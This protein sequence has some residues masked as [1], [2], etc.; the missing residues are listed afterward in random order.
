MR[1]AFAFIRAAWLTETSYRLNM[2]FS[3]ASLAFVVVPL[4]FVASA[5]EHTMASSIASQSRQYFSFV[6][7][8]AVVFN[9]ATASASALPNAV[10]NAIGRG[11]LESYLST[12]AS[13]GAVFAGLSGYGVVWAT[14]RSAVLLGSGALLG[15]RVVWSSAATMLLVLVL[16]I[17]AY[18]A[19]GLFA[20][21]LLLAFKTAGPIVTLTLSVSM[22]LGGVYYPT[23]V[24]PSWLKLVSNAL[25][26]SYG[27]RAFRQAALLGAPYDAVSHDVA[28]LA[29]YV[30]VLVSSGV[31]A[32]AAALHHA[33][34]AGTLATY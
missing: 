4:F 13:P 19:V 8:G 6:L 5:L 18:G 23:S 16:L 31:L 27:L 3:L 1:E 10:A 12:P 9:L 15:V 21:A 33:R 34:R 14:V 2:F 28:V 22:F 17:L 20:S 24:I 11:T 32:V 25:P 29:A 26:L 30:V 7:I